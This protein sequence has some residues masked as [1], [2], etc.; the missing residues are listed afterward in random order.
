MLRQNEREEIIKLIYNGYDLNLLAFEL[1]IP[2]EELNAYKKQLELRKFV[3]ESIQKGNVQNAIERLINFIHTSQ[4]SVVERQMLAELEAYVNK[5]NIDEKELEAIEEEK[6]RV[7]LTKNIDDILVELKVSIPKRKN[8]NL[9][10][11]VNQ[12]SEKK[13][14]IEQ[15]IQESCEEIKP[16]YEEMIRKYKSEIKRNSP[17]ISNARNLL[18]FTYFRAGKIE[19]ARNELISLIEQTSNYTA[20][21]QLIHL[22]KH[23]GNLEDAKLWSYDGLDKFPDS[24]DI[25]EQ[26]IA[27]AKQE[28]DDEEII[29][30]LKEIIAQDPENRKHNTRLKLMIE[31][32]Q[33]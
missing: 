30:Q 23:E 33:R 17:K 15:E 21:R 5:T 2:I 7:G 24:I 28:K 16:D 20:Y 12:Q 9:R 13:D 26:L 22:E 10:K 8:S 19:E 4:D 1:E 11:K 3:K 25:R 32:G 14:E 27:I 18:A 29:R 6:G 31:K